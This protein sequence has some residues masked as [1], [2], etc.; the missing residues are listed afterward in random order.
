MRANLVQKLPPSG[1][2]TRLSLC[3]LSLSLP[4]PFP[5]PCVLQK[6]ADG[7]FRRMLDIDGKP[8]PSAAALTKLPR[9]RKVE[10][11]IKSY[12]GNTLHLLG[13]GIMCT[14]KCAPAGNVRASWECVWQL[15]MTATLLAGVG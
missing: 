2:C 12:L 13:G 11:F 8:A 9:W 1:K 3:P 6:E 10:G 7:I 14:P 5:S 15:A 4:S